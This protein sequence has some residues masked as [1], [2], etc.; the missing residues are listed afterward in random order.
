MRPTPLEAQSPEK[1]SALIKKTAHL[2]GATLVNITKLNPGI[3][4]MSG[5][6]FTAARKGRI[7]VPS[8]WQHAIVVTTPRAWDQELSRPHLLGHELQMV[9]TRSSIAAYRIAAF[10]RAQSVILH[11]RHYP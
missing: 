7:E 8:W 2:F 9:I 11:E 10:I 6:C 3:G 1:A 4:F 5:E